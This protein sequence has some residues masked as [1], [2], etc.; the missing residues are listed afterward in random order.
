MNAVDEFLRKND[1]KSSPWYLIPSNS[2][3]FARR[4]TLKILTKRLSPL[5][6][7]FELP[8]LDKEQKKFLKELRKN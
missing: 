4:E 5:L 3:K 6:K 7:G 1:L 2:K 8:E